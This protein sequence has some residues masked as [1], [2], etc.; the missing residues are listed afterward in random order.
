MPTSLRWKAVRVLSRGWDLML[1]FTIV[2]AITCN[3]NTCTPS[4]E[5]AKNGQ[6]GDSSLAVEILSEW[7]CQY[8]S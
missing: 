6:F 4:D 3:L 8:D 5:F 1:I 2:Y 7:D